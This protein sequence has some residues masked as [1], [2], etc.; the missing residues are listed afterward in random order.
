MRASISLAGGTGMLVRSWLAQRRTAEAE[1][2]PMP[3]PT[4]KSILVGRGAIT[5]GQTLKP[6]DVAWQIWPDAGVEIAPTSRRVP[7]RS[8]ISRAGWRATRS[9]PASR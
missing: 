2:A 3:P 1:A 8:R 6:T 5:G 9:G 4:Q 7:R